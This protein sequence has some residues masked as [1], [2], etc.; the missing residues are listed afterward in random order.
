MAN[1]Y[2]YKGDDFW[3]SPFNGLKPETKKPARVQLHDATLR[4]GEQTPGV[5]F[6]KEDKIR[7]AKALDELGIDRIEAGMPAVSQEDYEAIQEIAKLGLNAKVMAFSRA[8]VK[9]VEMAAKSGVWGTIIELPSGE[10]RLK[11]QFKWSKQ[12]IIE[13]SI[14]AVQRA[15]ELGLYVTYFPFDTT[16]AE[17]DFLF[18]LVKTVVREG[19]PDSLAIID[20]LGCTTPSTIQYLVGEIKKLVDIPLEIH[21]HND[22]NV[23]VANELAAVEAGVEVVHGCIN[24]LGERTGN[25]ATEELIVGLKYLLGYDLN[26]DL[27]KIQSV[28]RLV[29]ELSNQKVHPYKPVV[30][31]NIFARETGSGIKMLKET[32][33][34]VF[35]FKPEVVGLESRAL[36]GKKSGSDSMEVKSEQYGIK[37]TEDEIKVIVQEIKA[38]SLREKRTVSDEEFLAIAKSVSGK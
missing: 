29:S 17:P 20:T 27:A 19:K 9:D 38:L 32:P 23:G 24:A 15:K 12:E 16:R 8:N 5:A 21:A 22:F 30:G 18:E 14:Q 4:D 37:L 11:W 7:I 35:P 26:V 13:K 36:L 28:S 1:I 6:R 2:N 31:S 25:A 10:P 34:A 3:V 33:L